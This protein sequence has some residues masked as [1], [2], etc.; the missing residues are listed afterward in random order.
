MDLKQWAELDAVS[1]NERAVRGAL[2]RA[3]T[4]MGLNP[5][6]D[7]M[8]NVVVIQRSSNPTAP[9]AMVSANMDEAGLIVTDA[10]GE[11]FLKVAPVGPVDPAWVISKPVRVGDKG[12]P[13]VI[14]EK[15]IHLQTQD[16]RKKA[17]TWRDVFV[18]IGARDKDEALA[19]APKGTYIAFDAASVMF[20]DG[21]MTGKA[22]SS[23]VGVECLVRLLGHRFP[24]T[25]VGVFTS[26]A[27]SGGRGAHGASFTE[28]P[29]VSLVLQGASANDLGMT[30]DTA[31]ELRC[32][33]GVG[34]GIMDTGSVLDR[35]LFRQ[36][37]DTA[38]EGNI[39]WQVCGGVQPAGD[40]GSIQ[41]AGEGIPTAVLS[42]PVRYIHSP[43]ETIALSDAEAQYLLARSVLKRVNA[44]E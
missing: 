42:I 31:M 41:L 16:E 33:H 17:F 4:D 29:D 18:D 40:A 12:I 34:I 3:L 30:E 37:C 5:V 39:S 11:G 2:M 15:P 44:W 21:R 13:G 20:G 24:C 22:L 28:K 8:G 6:I 23:R 19:K 32:G 26:L 7:R 9:V 10:N 27:L 25:L 1:G 36:I 35:K 14:G 43:A 38:A